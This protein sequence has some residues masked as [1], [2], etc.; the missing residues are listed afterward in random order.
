MELGRCDGKTGPPDGSYALPYCC[1]SV[2]Y[3]INDELKPGEFMTKTCIINAPNKGDMPDSTLTGTVGIG[4]SFDTALSGVQLVELIT[5]EGY[6][7]RKKAGDWNTKPK[8]YTY[9]DKNLELRVEFSDELPIIVR[10]DKKAYV[11]FTVRNIGGGYIS[12]I[13]NGRIYNLDDGIFYTLN[14]EV[15]Y[16][17][18]EHPDFVIEQKK[19]NGQFIVTCDDITDMSPLGNEFPTIACELNLP[20]DMEYLSNHLITV[21]I[22]YEYEER[23]DLTVKVIR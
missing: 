18:I 22:N 1:G 6:E 13:E 4:V 16:N 17:Y 20:E 9:R 11:Y 5:E 19:V 23:D 10:Q 21:K 3:K 14:G 2:C 15:S 12:D 8:A 7:I